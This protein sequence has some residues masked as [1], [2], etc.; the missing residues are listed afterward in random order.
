M[1]IAKKSLDDLLRAV[2]EELIEDGEQVTPTKGLCREISGVLL[3]LENPL[4]RLSR[5]ESKGTIFSCLGELLWYL[6]GKNDARFIDY[7]IPGYAQKFSDD[8][9]ETIHGAYGPRLFYKY[10]HNQVKNVIQLLRRKRSSRR[11]VIQLFSAAD[12]RADY[13]D[14]PCTCT[15]QFLIRNDTLDLITH[16]RSNDAFVGLPHDIFSF[17]MLQ[18]II[19]RSLDVELGTYKHLVGSLH[20]YEKDLEKIQCYIGEGYQES[21]GMDSMPDGDPWKDLKKFRRH[22]NSIRR[23]KQSDFSSDAI[24]AYWKLLLKLLTIFHFTKPESLDLEL[25]EQ[26]TKETDWGSL[27]FFVSKRLAGCSGADDQ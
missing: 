17:T 7:Y 25:A 20:L 6:S 24:D 9:G 23:G 4:L 15:L 13:K 22:A 19:A 1:Y 8:G 2:I 27:E 3:E 5:T 18:E 26:I 14:I 21:I 11:A 16:M 12:L 10:G